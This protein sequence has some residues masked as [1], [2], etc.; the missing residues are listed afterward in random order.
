MVIVSL[1]S[2]SEESVHLLVFTLHFQVYEYSLD[3]CHSIRRV[4]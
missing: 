2:S 3:E 4:N 1:I